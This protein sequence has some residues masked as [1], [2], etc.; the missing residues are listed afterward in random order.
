MYTG[1]FILHCLE[2]VYNP[3]LPL[4]FHC[5][6]MTGFVIV[7]TIQSTSAFNVGVEPNALRWSLTIIEV[8]A[9]CVGLGL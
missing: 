7:C 8:G 3:T 4:Y 6:L 9:Q 2:S 1:V 5:Y